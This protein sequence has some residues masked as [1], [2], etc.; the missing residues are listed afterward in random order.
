VEFS[1]VLGKYA[2]AI[3]SSFLKSYVVKKMY[4]VTEAISVDLSNVV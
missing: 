4:M 1:L 2:N 3:I